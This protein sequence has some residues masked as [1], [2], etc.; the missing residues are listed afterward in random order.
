MQCLETLPPTE[1]SATPCIMK[2]RHEMVSQTN[3]N[4]HSTIHPRCFRPGPTSSSAIAVKTQCVSL[5]III[6]FH[7]VSMVIVVEHLF[8]SIWHHQEDSGTNVEQSAHWRSC[9]FSSAS[10]VVN[11]S[12]WQHMGMD[13]YLLIPFL[14]EWT[15][16][17][18]LFWCSP[19]V[20]GFDTL[21]YGSSFFFVITWSNSI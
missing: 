5:G 13:Q 9:C 21:P 8:E 16:I 14:G 18:Q 3:I 10:I 4:K 12:T 1:T 6:S 7:P 15:S 2:L 19:G 11:K 17:Y 20:Q